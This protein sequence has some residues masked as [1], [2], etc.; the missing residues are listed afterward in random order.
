M[1]KDKKAS[2]PKLLRD[3]NRLVILNLLKNQ[4]SISRVEI[5]SSTRLSRPTVSAAIEQLLKEGLVRETG[6]VSSNEG[7]GRRRTLLEFQPEACYGIGMEVGIS[8]INI[9]L[10]DLNARIVKELSFKFKVN[11]HPGNDRKSIK[12]LVLNSIEKIIAAGGVG[13][14]KILGIGLGITGLVESSTGKLLFSSYHPGW[15]GLS[16]RELIQSKFDLP[17]Y[18]DN[19]I[20]VETLGEKW[21]GAGQKADNIIYMSITEGI[22]AGIIINGRLYR[23]K[24]GS[25]G[26]VGHT[27]VRA[28]GGI[29]TCGSRGCLNTVASEKALVAMARQAIASGKKSLIAELSSGKLPDVDTQC[30]LTAFQQK[31]A[32][33]KRLLKGV[34]GYLG[35]GVANL[36]NA[37]DPEMVILSGP[38]ME[39]DDFVLEEIKVQARKYSLPTL[40]HIKIVKAC[41]GG[42]SGV[43]GASTMVL[44][45]MF[46]RRS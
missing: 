31:D 21:F 14:N 20:K 42:K 10:T 3:I 15:N 36:I 7:A 30:I 11:A 8:R 4:R 18:V 35:I 23:G 26:E 2:D 45:K 39:V 13:I 44:E 17:V 22:S 16:F 9:A 5:A 29:C 24:D 34:A 33:A 38:V 12:R 1:I 27:I 40:R 28:R 25:A 6:K 46:K 43:I 37:F 41:L 19:N 32:L